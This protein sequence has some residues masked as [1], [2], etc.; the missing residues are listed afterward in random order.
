MW[1]QR[2]FQE[3]STYPPTLL[4]P[5]CLAGWALSGQACELTQ[6][7]AGDCHV[8]GARQPQGLQSELSMVQGGLPRPLVQSELSLGI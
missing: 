8:V 3:T 1:V 5:T 6:S 7:K 4:M 2:G